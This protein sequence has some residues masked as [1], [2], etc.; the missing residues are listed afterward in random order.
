MSA[1]ADL[2]GLLGR[3]QGGASFEERRRA[4]IAKIGEN[5]TVRRF[6]RVTAPTALGSYLH[7]TRIGTLVALR[8]GSEALARDLAM[9]VAALNPAYIDVAAVPA[10]L[11]AKERAILAGADEGREEAGGYHREDGRGTAAQVSGGNHARRSAVRQGSGD[12][13]RAIC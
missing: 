1:P 4:L 12:D 13:D 10:E 3:H 8:G 11:I 2:D 7:G 5:I 9:H 6:V